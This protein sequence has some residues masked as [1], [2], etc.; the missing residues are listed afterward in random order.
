MRVLFIGNSYTYFNDMP[1]MFVMECERRG[2]VCS[3]DS[4]TAGGYTLAHFVSDDNEYGVKAKEL[5]RGQRYDYVVLQEQ[6]VRP[7]SNPETFLGSVRS[8]I[9]LIRDNGATPVMYETW[10]RADGSEVLTAHGW[11]HETMQDRLTAA[12]EAAAAEHGAVLV[13]AGERF[14]EA[15][16]RGEPV[17]DPDGSHPSEYGSR[18]IAACFADALLN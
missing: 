5:L 6:S 1:K 9:P 3:A 4:V 14:H 17:F 16:R 11:D 18:L 7:A 2:A 13:R 12:Y 15:Y 8:L 10:G